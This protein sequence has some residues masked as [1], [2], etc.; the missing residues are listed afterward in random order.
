MVVYQGIKKTVVRSV[1]NELLCKIILAA[2]AYDII[3]SAKWILGDLNGLAN[4]L[5]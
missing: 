2:I 5:S 3:I 4:T 1:I